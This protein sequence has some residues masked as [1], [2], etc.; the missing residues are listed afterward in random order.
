MTVLKALKVNGNRFAAYSISDV[1]VNPTYCNVSSFAL[2]N[3]LPT[4][5]ICGKVSFPIKN[6]KKNNEKNN[7]IFE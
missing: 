7:F 2:V 3:I 6:F 5:I 1:V 4:T